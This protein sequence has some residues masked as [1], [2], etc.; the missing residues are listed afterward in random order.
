LGVDSYTSGVGLIGLGLRYSKED[1]SGVVVGA[2]RGGWEW[3]GGCRVS[4]N[5]A[6][7]T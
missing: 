4:I 7:H 2:M 5:Y 3:G 6:E 1:R